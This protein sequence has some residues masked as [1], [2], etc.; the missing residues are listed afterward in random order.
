MQLCGLGRINNTVASYPQR[1]KENCV[2]H[3]QGVSAIG[4]I[5]NIQIFGKNK[6]IG[7][8][9]PTACENIEIRKE[10]ENVLKDFCQVLNLLKLVI[11]L[12]KMK[13]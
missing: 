8:Q 12:T 5:M 6:S 13:L 3:L 11:F 1:S 2:T 7:F 4:A 10:I 9:Y